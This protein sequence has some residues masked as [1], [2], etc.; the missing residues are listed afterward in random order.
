MPCAST[1]RRN[2]NQSQVAMT[3]PP[4]APSTASAPPPMLTNPFNPVNP[5]NPFF[6]GADKYI[7]SKMIKEEN[8]DSSQLA[9]YI[10]I[11]MEMYPGTSIPPEEKA[12]LKCKS[13][14]NSVRKAYADFLGKPY[15]IPPVYTSK[16]L[17]NNTK[18]NI[19]NK[20]SVGGKRNKTRKHV[21]I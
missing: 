2:W 8:I 11:Y 13:K 19:P 21:N 7:E 10:T 16:T 15:I 9:Y 4:A 12:N 20:L 5:L 14:W 17:N 1:C 6:G 3:Y 18:K